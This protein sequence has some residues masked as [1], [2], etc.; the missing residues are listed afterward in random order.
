MDLPFEAVLAFLRT[1]LVETVLLVIAVCIGTA[2]FLLYIVQNHSQGSATAETMQTITS[3][4][5]QTITV[6]IEGAV[7]ASGVYELPVGSRIRDAVKAAG[8]MSEE[9]DTGFYR[10]NFNQA[11]YLNDQEKIYIPTVQ[12]ITGGLFAERKQLLDYLTP[13]EQHPSTTLE[14]GTSVNVNSAESAE[15]ETLPG[16]GQATAAKIIKLRPYASLQ[17]LVTRKAV[18][19]N[20]FEQIKQFI[21]L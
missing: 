4:T 3:S 19:K 18:S 6:D 12:E 17:D 21:S 20:V 5:E 8:G 2:S 9:A 11:R 10:R 1:Y 13:Q 14:N 15:L 16:V 7:V